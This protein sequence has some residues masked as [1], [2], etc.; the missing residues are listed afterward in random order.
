MPQAF[1]R[2]HVV[3]HTAGN[4]SKIY[5]QAFK[6]QNLQLN[7]TLSSTAYKSINHQSQPK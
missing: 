2:E 6:I 5:T 4:L 7:W 1:R 3:S